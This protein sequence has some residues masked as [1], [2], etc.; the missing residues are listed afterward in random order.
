MTEA[1]LTIARKLD[2]V[3]QGAGMTMSQLALA[4]CLRRPELT[5]CIIGASKEDQLKENIRASEVTFD[6]SVRERVSAILGV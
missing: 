6:D 5:S 4:W 2:E 3:A 1:N